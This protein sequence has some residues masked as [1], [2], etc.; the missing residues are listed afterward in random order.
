MNQESTQ[1]LK[2]ICSGLKIIWMNEELPHLTDSST[3]KKKIKIK[4]LIPIMK[5]KG[6]LLGTS[7]YCIAK[8]H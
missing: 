7:F 1:K 8:G 5:S 3:Y 4:L 2:N 6:I